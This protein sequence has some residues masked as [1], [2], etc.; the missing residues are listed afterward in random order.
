MHGLRGNRQIERVL[1]A[2]MVMT[3][4][5]A[6]LMM[7][8]GSMHALSALMGGGISACVNGLAYLS[9]FRPY[10]AQETGD[11]MTKLYGVEFQKLFLT[12]LLFAGVFA[13]MGQVS[14]AALFGT[15]LVVQV[16]VPVLVLISKDR[17]K[18]G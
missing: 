12:G 6:L 5:I 18:I 2:Q 1:L 4:V 3:I 9:V 7:V 13:A 10:R 16:G 8:F 17:N 11:L 15:Y 14:L